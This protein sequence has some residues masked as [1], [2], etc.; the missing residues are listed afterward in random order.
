MSDPA[1][2][3][4][5][6]IS[7]RLLA[8]LLY[9]LWLIHAILHGRKYALARYPALRMACATLTDDLPRIWVHAAS[10][11]EVRAITPLVRALQAQGDEILFTSFTASGYQTIQH[12]FGNDL[13]SAIIPIDCSWHCKRFLRAHNIRL[14]VVM[15]TELWPELLFQARRCGIDLLLVNA[16][17]S[18][19]S[20]DS[21]R[22]GRTVLAATLGYFSGLLTRSNH[23]REALQQL[24]VAADRIRILGNLKAHKP[25]AA[26]PERLLERDYLLLASSH[27]GE[28]LKLLCA[29][30]EGLRQILLVIAPRHPP[31]SN[32]IQTE[33]DTLGLSYAVRSLAQPVTDDTDVYLADTLGEMQALM[34]HARA[35][36]MGGSFNDTGGHNLIEPASLG[37]AIITGPSDSNIRHDIEMLGN[38]MGMIQVDSVDAC[39]AAVT[40][41]VEQPE[42]AAALGKEARARLAQQPDIQQAYLDAINARLA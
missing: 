34:A 18:K 28:E 26:T 15:E 31:R 17:L 42:R 21:G 33:L 24:G 19:K 14:A 6:G 2:A 5:P 37:C 13:V 35:V 16:R 8:L 11:G 22:F 30:P 25:V 20:L 39:W 36:I 10:V 27:A 41:L 4:P 29:R 38:E 3:L 32:S 12:E 40:A 1:K 7:Y 9:P 23:D